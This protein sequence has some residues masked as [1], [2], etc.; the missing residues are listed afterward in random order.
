MPKYR[1]YAEKKIYL[2]CV[3]EADTQEEAERIADEDLITDDFEQVNTHFTM[4][5]ISQEPDGEPEKTYRLEYG[6][7]IFHDTPNTIGKAIIAVGNVPEYLKNRPEFDDSIFYYCD[8]EEEYAS[9]FDKSNN[10]EF[11]LLKESN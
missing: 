6:D 10:G 8:T 5:G 3:I 1:I 11:Y 9:L 4:I 2:E 7:F